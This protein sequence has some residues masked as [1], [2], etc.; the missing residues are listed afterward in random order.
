[1]VIQ[2]HFSI[3]NGLPYR[4]SLNRDC[5]QPI[6]SKP[7]L[8]SH[9]FLFTPI[10]KFKLGNGNIETFGKIKIMGQ[11]CQSESMGLKTSLPEKNV[12]TIV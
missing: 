1:M 3:G 5:Y 12:V 10:L 11:P 4:L 2:H 6:T 9:F 7:L 8:G